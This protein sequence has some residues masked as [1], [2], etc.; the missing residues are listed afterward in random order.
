MRARLARRRSGEAP[1]PWLAAGLPT[2]LS[3][4]LPTALPNIGSGPAAQRGRLALAPP[5]TEPATPLS[6]DRAPDRTTDRSTRLRHDGPFRHLDPVWEPAR[7]EAWHAA[8]SAGWALRSARRA[9]A[10][11]DPAGS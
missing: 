8:L 4:A 9:A 5:A 6:S 2:A 11:R 10:G 7:V 3:T 1:Q